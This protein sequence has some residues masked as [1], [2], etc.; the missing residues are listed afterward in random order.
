MYLAPQHVRQVLHY[1]GTLLFYHFINFCVL[2][3]LVCLS[4]DPSILLIFTRNQHLVWLILYILFISISLILLFLDRFYCFVVSCL[5]FF[6][7][8]TLSCIFFVSEFSFLLKQ[9]L[10]VEPWLAYYLLCRL[11]LCVP[12]AGLHHAIQS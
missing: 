7:S 2:F 5:F 6:S 4:R 1:Q 8:R 9:S 12:S 11:G 10:V 3:L